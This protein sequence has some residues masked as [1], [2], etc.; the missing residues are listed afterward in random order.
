MPILRRF[1]DMNFKIGVILLSIFII[2]TFPVIS[3]SKIGQF[4]SKTIRMNHA[5]N[6]KVILF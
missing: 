6:C 1:N 4:L 3:R 2:S 5:D